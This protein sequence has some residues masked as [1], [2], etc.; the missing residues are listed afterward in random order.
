[1]LGSLASALAGYLVLRAAT[2][3]APTE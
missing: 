2:R 3:P 1:L